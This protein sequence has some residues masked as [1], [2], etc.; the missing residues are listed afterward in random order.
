[1]QPLAS[2]QSYVDLQFCGRPRAIAAIVLHGPGGVALLDP[3]PTSTLPTLTAALAR[4]GIGIADV[5]TILLTHIHLDHAGATGTLVRENPSIRVHVHEAGAPHMSDPAKL[6]ASATR[7]YGDAMDRLWGEI[8]P[9]PHDA[10]VPLSGGERLPVAGRLLKVAYTPGHAS[11]HVSF[12]SAD[13]GV[14]FV[15]D[16]AGVMVVPDGFIL[17]PTPPPDID[18]EVWNR[19]LAVI[20]AWRP[21][22]LFLTHFGAALQP[23]SHLVQLRDHLDLVGQLSKQS[24]TQDVDDGGKESWFVEQL[25]LQL[26]RRMSDAEALAYET[27]ARFDLNWRGLARYWRK[28]G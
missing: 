28:K 12:L 26:R 10:L 8:A 17:P 13:T 11:H 7:L 23:A 2:G 25:R 22:T 18:L 14:A 19:S 6:V 5:T 15:G 20:D 4:S 24:L 3:G 27:S 1:M 9:V 21:G 16:T